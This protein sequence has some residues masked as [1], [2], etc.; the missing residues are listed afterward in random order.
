MTVPI[1]YSR[2]CLGV[3]APL[4][5][6]ETHLS[7]GLPAFN[8]VGLPETAVRES[9][10]RVRSAIINSGYEFPAR[11]ITV[12]LAPGDLPKHGTRF[13]LAIALGILAASRQIA[14][15]RLTAVECIA[16]LALDGGL[17]PVRA[18]LPAALAAKRAAR[19]LLLARGDD[20]EAALVTE[21]AVYA[22]ETLGAICRHIDGTG[23]LNRTICVTGTRTDLPND[24]DLS[25]IRGQFQ[26]KRALEIAAA[27]GHNLLLIGP[28]G[29]GKTM[30]ATR[31]PG[32]LP[33]LEEDEAF[34]TA[35]VTSIS[36]RGFDPSQWRT[37]PFR[38]PHHTSSA[39]AL[40]GG[41]SNPR[42]GEVSLAQNGVLFLDEL[43][44][45][46]RRVLEVLREPLETGR[47]TI[48]RAARSVDFPARFQLIAAM[49]PCPCGYYGDPSG[50]CVCSSE[51]IGR[52]RQRISGPLLDRIDLHIEVA[53]QPD[54]LDPDVE[55][56]GDSST[57]VRARVA[58]ARTVQLQRQSK[59]NSALGS[60][61]VRKFV[62][63]DTESQTFMRQAFER[64]CLSPR[65]YDRIC[66]VA[67]T[68][69]DLAAA[70]DVQ[71]AHL[72]EALS[73]RC[74]DR[75]SA[76]HPARPGR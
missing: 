20:T 2:A 14:C 62:P 66:K 13:D 8:L 33:P 71:L 35:A 47:V 67:R 46:E 60:G 59:L 52:Y 5:S 36:A 18:V 61:E 17:R 29:T 70:T 38:S 43:P 21:L 3:E 34:A 58:R 40:I 9:K 23:G 57:L 6:V 30:L 74:L 75:T 76:A 72:G 27:G 1:V 53:R 51:Q 11:R 16:E 50:R 63:L 64:F 32:L 25:D 48:S 28:P 44:E 49:N 15:D 19:A 69:A 68:I 56:A 26:G 39:V 37:R 24:Q 10:D 4:I 31:L 45:F 42:P 7:P 54:W 41:G 65:A 55:L 73:L 12:N 22:A